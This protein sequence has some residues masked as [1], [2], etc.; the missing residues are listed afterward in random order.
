MG[1]SLQ[2]WNNL[3]GMIGKIQERSISEEKIA[4][5]AYDALLK[6]VNE[7]NPKWVPILGL[8]KRGALSFPAKPTTRVEKAGWCFLLHMDERGDPTYLSCIR[9]SDYAIWTVTVPEDLDRLPD[10]FG[11]C[12][13][14]D[15]MWALE[16][17][18]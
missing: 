16:E 10:E 8:F 13:A 15:V 5:L 7:T 17:G 12:D 6:E 11:Q 9:Q 1:V 18:P 3:I 4:E 14:D 2:K